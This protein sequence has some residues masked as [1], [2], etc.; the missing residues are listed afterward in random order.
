MK[1]LKFYS[2][3]LWMEFN[4]LEA[5]EPLWENSLLFTIQFQE[6]PGNHLI[7]FHWMKSWNDI[8]RE[9]IQ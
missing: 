7:S 8:D 1:N 2:S 9:S 6:V 4:Y 5:T 3:F